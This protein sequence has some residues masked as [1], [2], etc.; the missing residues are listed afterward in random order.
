[1]PPPEI[2]GAVVCKLLVGAGPET[3][4]IGV[5]VGDVSR[6]DSRNRDVERL[7]SWDGER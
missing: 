4:V 5:L 6:G 3:A 7:L 1:V 2:C